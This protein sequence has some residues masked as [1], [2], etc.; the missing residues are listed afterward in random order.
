M[1]IFSWPLLDIYLSIHHHNDTSLSYT[2]SIYLKRNYAI[3]YMYKY[4]KSCL[5]VKQLEVVASF[6]GEDNHQDIAIFFGAVEVVKVSGLN[7]NQSAEK[8]QT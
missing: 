5:R 2:I 6:Q 8:S 1:E 3:E 4:K 7:L